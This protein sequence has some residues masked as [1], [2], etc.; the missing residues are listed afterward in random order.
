MEIYLIRHGIAAEAT[1]Y[2]KDEIRPLTEKGRLKT[3]KV[4]ERLA[5]LEVKIDLLLTSPLVRAKQTTEI[6]LPLANKVE[7]SEYLAPE[8]TLLEWLKQFQ[9]SQ[10]IQTLALV[11]HQPNLGNW[12][13]QL[14]WGSSQEKLNLKKAGIIGV[15]I[16]VLDVNLGRGTL[17]LLVSPKWLLV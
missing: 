6:L 15:E 8:G 16:P 5:Q 7:E 10:K 3:Q 1:D 13:E 17:F 12:A 9:P 14:V 11:G 4:A 2:E